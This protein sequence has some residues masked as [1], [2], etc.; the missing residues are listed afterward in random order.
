MKQTATK[1][2]WETDPDEIIIV[3]NRTGNNYILDLP[4]GRFRLDAGRRMR[5]YRSIL[6]VAQVN[7]LVTQGKLA[8]EG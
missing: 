5:T 7:D 3:V 6:K 2:T 1:P 8:V 4:A